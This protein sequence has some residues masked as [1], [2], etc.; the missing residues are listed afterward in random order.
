MVVVAVGVIQLLNSSEMRRTAD[1]AARPV[2]Q[3]F[4]QVMFVMARRQ[5]GNRG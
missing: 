2:V 3:Y 4:H 1:A 5:K